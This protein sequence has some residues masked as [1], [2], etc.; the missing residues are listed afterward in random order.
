MLP[1]L[2]ASHPH[3]KTNNPITALT[4]LPK[5]KG[6]SPL[7]YL[8]VRGPSMIALASAALPPKTVDGVNNFAENVI[9]HLQL[10][11]I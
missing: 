2:K 4:G 10:N 5:G 11:K 6:S 7:S 3:H 8:P 1:E 9:S